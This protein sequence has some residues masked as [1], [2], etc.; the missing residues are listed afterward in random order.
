MTETMD[1]IAYAFFLAYGM[2]EEDEELESLLD[3]EM[4]NIMDVDVP[5]AVEESNRNVLTD[6]A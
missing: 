5:M 2:T 6:N 3:V 4:Y 1:E